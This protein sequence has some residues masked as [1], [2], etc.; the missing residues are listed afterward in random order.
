MALKNMSLAVATINQGGGTPIVFSDDG[1]TIPNGLHLVVPADENYAER[2]QLT[3]KYRPPTVD[4]KTGV[5][6]KD[7][8]TMTFVKPMTLPSGQ[9]VFNTIRL[10]REV[11]PTL[12]ALDAADLNKIGAQLLEQADNLNFWSAGSLS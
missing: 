11:H 10:E 5:Y 2:R 12:P 1:V 9:I 3:V 7:K 8:K 4:A 6:G